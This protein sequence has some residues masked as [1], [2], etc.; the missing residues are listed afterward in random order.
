MYC[1]PGPDNSNLINTDIPVPT[2]P[3]NKAKIKYKVG[4]SKTAL[5]TV[6]DSFPSYGSPQV[7]FPMRFISK[8]FTIHWCSLLYVWNTQ[9]Q[10]ESIVKICKAYR[11]S[12]NTVIQ[13]EFIYIWFKSHI[14][15][16]SRATLICYIKDMT[17][18]GYISLFP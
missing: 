17:S 13:L 3:E 7:L 5:R 18:A 14:G 11:L 8:D 2:N 16:H 15:N 1:T 10:D 6:R 9:H 12:R 4:V